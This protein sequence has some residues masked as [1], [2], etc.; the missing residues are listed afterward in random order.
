M[1]KIYISFIKLMCFAY[2]HKTYIEIRK[3]PNG[4]INCNLSYGLSTSV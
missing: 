4:K 3:I 1:K 2:Q